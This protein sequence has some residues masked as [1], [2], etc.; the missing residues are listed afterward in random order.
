MYLAQVIKFWTLYLTE[1]L[2]AMRARIAQLV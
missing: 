1:K 2:E